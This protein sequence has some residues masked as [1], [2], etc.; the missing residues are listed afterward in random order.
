M[1]SSARPS[2]ASFMAVARAGL[3]SE[4]AKLNR[5]LSNL[6]A[7]VAAGADMLTLVAEI[8]KREARRAEI[9]RELVRP[10]V[11]REGIKRALE[12]QI[13]KWRTLLRGRATHG[14]T[15]LSRLTGGQIQ[16]YSNEKGVWWGADG[17]PQEVLSGLYT[18]LA[19]DAGQ[20][21]PDRALAPL[22]RRASDSVNAGL[23]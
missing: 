15:V 20:L 19:S 18:K 12:A 17:R 9:E 13:A 7:A 3:E 8:K 5:E 10:A 11:D 1:A 14:R 23:Q 21:E 6:G 2:L 16:V 22:N 4:R